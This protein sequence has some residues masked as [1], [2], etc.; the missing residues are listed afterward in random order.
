MAEALSLLGI[1]RAVVVHG[2]DRLDEV[3]LSAPT[4]VT[5]VTPDESYEFQWTPADFGFEPIDRTALLVNNAEESAAK[6]RAILANTP[7]P[8]RDIVVTN[9]AAALWTA[10]RAEYPLDA[11]NLAAEAIA[12]G[13][14]A[15]L[16]A[17][18]SE[19]T[20]A[21]KGSA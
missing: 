6:I 19:K 21:A 4:N 14:A 2:T 3:S 5:I 7:G 9:A 18:L 8:P 11:A 15:D 12:S 10:G 16:L 17:R 13:A 1:H 20:N